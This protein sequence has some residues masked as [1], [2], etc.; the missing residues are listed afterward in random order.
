MD[1][2]RS[3]TA[4]R[5]QRFYGLEWLRFLLGLYIV[6]FHTLHTYPS[7]S[8]WSGYVTSVG[9]FSTSAFFVLSGFLL[10]HV[11]FG[12]TGAMRE[13][14]RSF[15]VKRFSNLYPLHIGSVLLA[16]AISS[17]V[18]YL[19][20]TDQD[21]GASIRFVLYDV[22]DGSSMA[23]ITHYMSN[24]EL[25]LNILLNL[26]LLHAWNPFYL[27]FNPVTWSISTLFFFYLVFPWIAPRLLKI[28][29]LRRALAITN[30]VYLIP[31]L[32]VIALTDFGAPET[33]LLHRNPIIR[34]PEFVAGILLYA[35]YRQRS[36]EGRLL[37]P[38]QQ[39]LLLGGV[40]VAVVIGSWLLQHG[41]HAWYY[42]LH[43]GFFLPAQLALIYVVA[44]WPSPES[45]RVKRLATR[46][47]GASLPMF[48]L[49]VP[50]FVIF[51]RAE[52]VLAGE[53]SL[54]L[55]SVS[56][57]MDAA[58]P[59]SL[60]AYPVFLAV[61]VVFC[62]LFQERVVVRIRHWL[63]RRLLPLVKAESR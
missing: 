16:M 47:G 23:S 35:L 18:G 3:S 52:R 53:P 32:L 6:I 2:S 51:T 48:A 30:L 54:C 63:Q 42:L 46:L 59:A 5:T 22:N 9:F 29:A 21:A 10:T 28:A 55:T 44:H 39:A 14:A 33:G 25:V 50:L 26:T 19:A 17:L 13:P 31:P 12:A 36:R 20:I 7:I 8:D 62:M 57:C 56:R 43:N 11:Y 61:T 24:P 34:L 49:H 1:D 4:S 58:G 38:G 27:T 45:H 60:W 15:W 41:A 40:A 37:S